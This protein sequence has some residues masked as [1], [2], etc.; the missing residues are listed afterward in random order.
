MLTTG[1]MARI[2]RIHHGRMVDVRA[3]NAKLR[4]RAVRIV[5]DLTGRADDEARAT[6]ES[7]DWWARAAIIRLELGLG[8]EAARARA[9]AHQFLADALASPPI[10]RAARLGGPDG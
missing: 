7:V 2:G 8:A 4:D 3:S 9:R 6:L 1:A 10:D 5:A